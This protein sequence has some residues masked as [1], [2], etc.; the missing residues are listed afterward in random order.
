MDGKDN[1]RDLMG[2]PLELYLQKPSPLG[3]GTHPPSTNNLKSNKHAGSR[4]SINTL[5]G[6]C[7]YS[8]ELVTRGNLTTPYLQIFCTPLPVIGI[9]DEDPMLAEMS[10]NR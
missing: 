6:G 7:A 4:Y 8:N 3:A 10:V 9:D 2:G 5:T 1:A